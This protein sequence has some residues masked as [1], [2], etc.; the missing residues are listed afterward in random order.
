MSQA[1]GEPDLYAVLGVPGDATEDQILRAFR[2]RALLDHP[3][4][5]GDAET[6][7]S[8]YRARETLLDP[9]RRSA[10]DRRRSAR[11]APGTKAPGT[12]APGTK[13]PR[14]TAPETAGTRP[15]PGSAPPPPSDT[16]NAS[17][18]SDP[19]DPFVWESGAGPAAGPGAGAGSDPGRTD[20]SWAY[21]DVFPAPGPGVS[22]RRADRFGWWD[23]VD[24]VTE[25]PPKGRRRRHR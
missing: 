4:R 13:A 9:A 6:F 10:Y 5:G 15:W 21:T 17:D 12:K 14:P 1:A 11:A 8:L 16:P 24:P 20:G 2:R 3:D 22:W 18:P 7:R 25:P 19:S 23:P